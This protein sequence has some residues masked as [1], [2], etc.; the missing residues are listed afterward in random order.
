MNIK[1]EYSIQLSI[2]LTSS[3]I[4]FTFWY[5]NGSTVSFLTT[6]LLCSIKCLGYVEYFFCVLSKSFT[7]SISTLYWSA[8]ICRM[9]TKEYK[10]CYITKVIS[11]TQ[12]TSVS[13]R[14]CKRL[15]YSMCIIRQKYCSIPYLFILP[16]EQFYLIA[17]FHM[18]IAL[19]QQ[20]I[21]SHPIFSIAKR[22]TIHLLIAFLFLGIIPHSN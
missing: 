12:S 6:H 20:K 22:Y 16:D 21:S 3:V 9:L 2:K 15:S 4:S 18:D 17:N 19:V 5:F 11:F 10:F 1:D 14:L 8:I 13:G 7:V